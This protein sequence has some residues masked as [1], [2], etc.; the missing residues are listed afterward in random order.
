MWQVDRVVAY[1]HL[2]LTINKTA[3]RYLEAS[4]SIQS[5]VQRTIKILKIIALEAEGDH[6]GML[7]VAENM[8]NENPSLLGLPQIIGEHGSPCFT[9]DAYAPVRSFQ[10]CPLVLRGI[11][12]P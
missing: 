12:G 5:H 4:E 1:E 3:D 6:Q 11:L 8:T 7:A 2:T 9:F 10:C